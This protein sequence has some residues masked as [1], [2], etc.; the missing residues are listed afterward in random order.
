MR[1]VDVALSRMSNFGSKD[2]EVVM[3]DRRKDDDD[4]DDDD[5]DV[6][7][8]NNRRDGLAMTLLM[9]GVIGANAD[10]R[11]EDLEGVLVFESI[12]NMVAT[13]A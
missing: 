2:R 12:A 3:A 9:F 7:E 4:D 8:K 1:M 6:D 5:D 11:M 13:T 10:T